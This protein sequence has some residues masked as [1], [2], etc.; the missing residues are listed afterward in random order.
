MSIVPS[1]IWPSVVGTIIIICMSPSKVVIM[2]IFLNYGDVP[3]KMFVCLILMYWKFVPPTF[4]TVW[5]IDLNLDSIVLLVVK[6][7]E[8]PSL[9]IPVLEVLKSLMT[10]LRS[11]DSY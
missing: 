10:C 11:D 2:K 9:V 3:Q 1:V 6:M 4:K 8:R 7:E 5:S